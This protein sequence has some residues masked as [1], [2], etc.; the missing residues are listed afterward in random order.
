VKPKRFVIG[1]TGGIGTGKSAALKA[2]EG[3]GAAT[4]CLDQIAKEQAKPGRE[5]YRAIVKSFGRCILNKDATIDR[6][7]LGRVIFSDKRAKA[8]LE[9][10]TH[11]L[12]L[13][14]MKRIV[15]K[16][17][18]VVIVDVPLLFEKNLQKNFDATI[19][20][21]CKPQTQLKRIIKRDGLDSKEARLRIKAQLPLD[22]KRTLADVTIDN[23]TNI[24][25]FNRHINEYYLG[26]TLLHR[27]L[28]NGNHH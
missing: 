12:I 16:L 10:A 15:S 1:L 6:A 3:L 27:G 20:I 22:Q 2:F 23:D 21:A 14:E 24:N 18:G 26:I 4:V 17:T 9:R 19:L 5:G 11:P 13:K 7:L 28:P 25:F 8:G